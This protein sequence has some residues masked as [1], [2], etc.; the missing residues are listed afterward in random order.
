M[1]EIIISV[2]FTPPTYV[3]EEGGLP[4][5]Q[6]PDAGLHDIIIPPEYKTTA[7]LEDLDL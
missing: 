1:T 6:L 5:P 2:N 4:P 3:V 7:Q